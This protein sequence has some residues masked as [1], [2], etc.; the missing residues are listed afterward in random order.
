[1]H[2]EHECR[3][4]NS[5][6]FHSLSSIKLFRCYVTLEETSWHNDREQDRLQEHQAGDYVEQSVEPRDE[7]TTAISDHVEQYGCGESECDHDLN[8][9]VL[10]LSERVDED[11]V[12]LN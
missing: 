8:H 2:R 12:Y 6:D 10:V 5:V 9:L 7:E 4:L 1:M 11:E 3:L